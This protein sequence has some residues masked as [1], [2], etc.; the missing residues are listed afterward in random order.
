MSVFHYFQAG[1][2]QNLREQQAM[3]HYFL[4]QP[5][6]FQLRFLNRLQYQKMN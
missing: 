1:L 2:I 6:E 4:T 3:T 5:V